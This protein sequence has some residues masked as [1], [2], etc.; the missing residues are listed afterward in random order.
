MGGPIK[1]FLWRVAF[2][3]VVVATF[4]ASRAPTPAFV[5]DVA[6]LVSTLVGLWRASVAI[7]SAAKAAGLVVELHSCRGAVVSQVDRQVLTGLRRLQ[8]SVDTSELDRL[9]VAK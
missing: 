9:G 6:K 5:D 2:D 1:P 3:P 7:L 8:L 4:S